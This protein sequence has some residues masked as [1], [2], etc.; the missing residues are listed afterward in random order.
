M[1]HAEWTRGRIPFIPLKQI[2]FLAAQLTWVRE[3]TPAAIVGARLDAAG[4]RRGA[5]VGQPLHKFAPGQPPGTGVHRRGGQAARVRG[6]RENRHGLFV[7]FAAFNRISCSLMVSCLFIEG[8]GQKE[9]E[10]EDKL[11]NVHV[12]VEAVTTWKIDI[13]K[14]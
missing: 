8:S 3:V 14:R 7:R 11:S 2:V 10:K 1:A 6:C 12:Q 13:F 5:E 4:A 9:K